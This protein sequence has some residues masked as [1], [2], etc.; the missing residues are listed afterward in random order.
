FI[1]IADEVQWARRD[2][3]K[4]TPAHQ[5]FFPSVR[6][7]NL[8]RSDFDDGCCQL[9]PVGMIGN[10]E[11]QFDSALLGALTNAHPAGRESGDRIRKTP[12]PAIRK[13]RRRAE[14]D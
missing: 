10:D 5:R 7:P 3:A 6:Y 8:P 14:D 2:A 9:V 11:R 12:R 13:S 4:L 1:F